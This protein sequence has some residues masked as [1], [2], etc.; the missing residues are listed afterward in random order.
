[1]QTD[2]AAASSLQIPKA[3]QEGIPRRRRRVTVS[4]RQALSAAVEV[5]TLGAFEDASLAV[6][7]QANE[8]LRC[9]GGDTWKTRVM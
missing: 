1:L 6:N 9:A 4:T 5:L 2:N 7:E 8:N 3:L